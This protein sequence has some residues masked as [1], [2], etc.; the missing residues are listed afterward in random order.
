[1][2]KLSDFAYIYEHDL[3]EGSEEYQFL[4]KVTKTIGAVME[5][6]I[7]VDAFKKDGG[8]EV[9]F[10]VT[11]LGIQQRIFYPGHLITNSLRDS[12]A[13]DRV[14]QT[15]HTQIESGLWNMMR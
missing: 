11:K 13:M 9:T 8:I 4:V 14:Y 6:K 7:T 2:T 15:S 10:W 1:M 5:N 12:K 3:E